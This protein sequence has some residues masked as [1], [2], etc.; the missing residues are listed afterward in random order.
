MKIFVASSG[1]CGTMFASEMF[2]QLTAIPSFHEPRPQCL[3]KVLYEVNNKARYSPEVVEELK[4]KVARVR[5]DSRDGNYFESSQMFIKSYVDMILNEFDT[6]YCIYLFR[7]PLKTL[8]SY[9]KQNPDRV[10]GWFLKPHWTKNVLHLKNKVGFWERILWEW[11]EVK[12]RY[13][14]YKKEFKKTYEFDFR[15][16]NNAAEW[17][18]LF[19]HFGV[20][21]KPFEELPQANKNMTAKDD[22][23][24]LEGLIRDWKKPEEKPEKQLETTKVHLYAID[25]VQ[26]TVA[27]NS[28]EVNKC[29]M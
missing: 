3:H 11:Y 1:R 27:L 4:N 26:R 20:E 25:F 17:K 22:C 29:G 19:K 21:H 24:A 13:L 28:A 6:V 2:R 9:Y 23:E 18:R 16:I 12:A 15:K 5:E 8:L 7:N 10:T 14:L